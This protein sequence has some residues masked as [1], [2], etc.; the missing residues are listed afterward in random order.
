MEAQPLV[1]GPERR[2]DPALNHGVAERIAGDLGLRPFE[3]GDLGLAGL[4]QYTVAGVPV[5]LERDVVKMSVR[6]AADAR[7]LIAEGEPFD[8]KPAAAIEAGDITLLNGDIS[9]VAEAIA[10]S[11]NTLTTIKQNLGWAFGY[12]VLAIPIAAAG[13]LNPI[14]A[15][16]AMA[17]SSV[18]VMTNSLRLRSKARKI[19]RES[20]N[21]Y[22]PASGAS[23]SAIGGPAVAMVLAAGILL[24]PL[25]IF[26]AISRG[27]FDAEPALA[28]NETRVTLK[29]FDVDVSRSRLPAGEVTLFVEHEEERHGDRGEQPGDTHDLVVT[30]VND[31][32][33][34]EIVGRTEPLEMGEDSELHLDLEPGRYEVFCSIVEEV[35][36]ETANHYDLGMRDLITVES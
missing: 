26:T 16:A 21:T 22:V 36:G 9:K 30:R 15:G 1:D 29:N 18:S 7:R 17:F 5:G 11:R 4:L 24:V 6:Q 13:L 33:S 2:G 25:A 31:D 8:R 14:I 12:N 34:R 27:W 32:G 3:I 19:A 23:W 28:A 10:L 35:K 20:G